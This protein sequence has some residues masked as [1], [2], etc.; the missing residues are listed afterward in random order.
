MCRKKSNQA[1]RI[2]ILQQ[3]KTL[4]V[5]YEVR[6]RLIRA[7]PHFETEGQ[8]YEEVEAVSEDSPCQGYA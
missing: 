3:A 2:C 7:E 1:M 6:L 4:T 5:K 8:L